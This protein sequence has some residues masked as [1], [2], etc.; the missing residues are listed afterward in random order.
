MKKTLLI[1]ATV[2]GIANI[3]SAQT[4]NPYAPQAQTYNNYYNYGYSQQPVQTQVKK[5]NSKHKQFSI[6]FDYVLGEASIASNPFTIESPLVGGLTYNGNTR[7]FDDS[8]DS[9][10]L[11][12]GYRPFRYF[13]FE[14]FYQKSLSDNQ[15][16][17]QESYSLD[18]RFAIA[19]YNLEY[20]AYGLDALGFLPVAPWFEVLGTVGVAKYDF[21]AEVDFSSY[22]YSTKQKR[23]ENSLKFSEDQLAYRYGL[24]FQIWLSKRLAFRA[25]YRYT[26]IGGDYF[27]DIEEL[28]LGLR[29]N[30]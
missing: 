14:V 18:P 27:D 13:G 8:I 22:I 30:F 5:Q 12:L 20:T 7:N 28:S 23:K 16:K 29:Y 4:Y 15:V 19:E 24:G 6:G 9:L 25:M 2:L 21:T 1:S 26:S 10:N 11:N 3:A 17:Y